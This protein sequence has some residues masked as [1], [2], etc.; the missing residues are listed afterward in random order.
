LVLEVP[1]EDYELPERFESELERFDLGLIFMWKQ[2]GEWQFDQREWET[3]RLNPD[4]KE[5]NALLKT[6]FKTS[7]REKE[8]KLAIGR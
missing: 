5:L 8:Y 3:D 1:D 7:D 6:F 2:K 4:P